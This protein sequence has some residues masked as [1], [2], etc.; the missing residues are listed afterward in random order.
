MTPTQFVHSQGIDLAVYTWGTASPQKPT[1][2]LVHGYPDTA[3]VWGATAEQL[4]EHYF[5]VAYDVRG[6]GH[7]GIA[8]HRAEYDLAYLV[9]DLAAVLDVVSP[10][11]AVHLVGHDWGSIQS[12]EAVTTERLQGRI[13][14]YTT[15]SGPSLDHAGHWIAR[16]L[17]SGS[18][19]QILQVLRPLLHSWYVAMFHLPLIAPSLWRV[20]GKW[21]PVLLAKIEGITGASVSPTQ[22][23]DG[24]HGIQ[25]Y[26][27]N[28]RNR[29][30]KPQV[31]TT[32]LPV[33]LI[34]LQ[35]DHFMIP[36]IWEDL[37][38]WVPNL[39]R[40]DFNAGHW[41]P[42]SHPRLLADWVAEFITFVE[43]Q[44]ASPALK[45]ARVM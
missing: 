44:Q 18:L 32:N 17:K 24:V 2:V 4:A 35:R 25:L 39:W 22:V 42:L 28:F 40:R 41:L 13:A 19:T 15:I 16:R 30:C 6:A 11:Q 37:P 34:V 14:S 29:V 26:R 27:A 36:E 12:W 20:F 45:L 9:Q 21:G 3:S 38:Q 1:I 10:Q 7:S 31:R 5:V 8:K 33:Q 23:Q 43:T